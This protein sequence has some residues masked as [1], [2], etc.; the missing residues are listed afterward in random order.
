MRTFGIYL[1][2]PPNVDL[3]AEGLGRHLA[4]FLRE[5]HTRDD[6]RFVVSCPSWM[7]RSFRDFLQSARI[8]P[9]A[10]EIIAPNKVPVILRIYEGFEAYRRYR[11]KTGKRRLSRL[12]DQF[13]RWRASIVGRA[14]RRIVTTRSPVVMALLLSIGAFSLL[15]R[16]SIRLLF[17]LVGVLGTS[18]GLRHVLRHGRS[19]FMGILRVSPKDNP[20]TVRLYRLME[21][22]EAKLLSAQINQ[23]REISAWYAP[24]AFWPHFNDIKAPRIMC[25]PDVVLSEFP[26]GFATID[27]QRVLETF[28]LIEKAIRGGD[29]FVTYSRETKTRTLIERYGVP[30]DAT[31]VIPHGANRLDHLIRVS[32]SSNDE[33]ATDVFCSNLFSMALNKSIGNAN[34]TRFD[35][36]DVRFIF[37]ASQFRPNKNVVSLL[38]AYHHLARHR[39]VGHKLILTGNPNVLPEIAQFIRERD[40]QNDVLCLHGLTDRELAACYRLADL[41]VN[42]SLSEGG[43]PFTLTE[44]LSVGTP[45]V[46]SRIAVTEEVITDPELQGMMLFDPY[47]WKDM[48]LRIEWALFN[49]AQLLEKQRMLYEQL[50]KRSWRNVVDEYINVL[51]RISLDQRSALTA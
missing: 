34:P 19:H 45:V 31:T 25:V 40:L 48:A 8:P 11:L 36:G 7:R 46:M 16:Q 20:I 1:C 22:A 18:I 10:F 41:A 28:R 9:D 32:G 51:D 30:A 50:S 17:R 4:E 24:T 39:Y 33:N 2:Y 47:N 27:Q 29:R 14:E 21:K 38:R 49:N 42:P 43:C 3:R 23:R 26:V 12:A 35:S 15:F 6:A 5:A 13:T 37:Y 44:A